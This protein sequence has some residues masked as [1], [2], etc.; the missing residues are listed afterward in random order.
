MDDFT[1]DDNPISPAAAVVHSQ[2]TLVDASSEGILPLESIHFSH[3]NDRVDS[4]LSGASAPGHLQATADMNIDSG[5]I[6][7]ST[8][9]QPSLKEVDHQPLGMLQHNSLDSLEPP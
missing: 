5:P 3:E 9:S 1:V 7:S 8:H 2:P 4:N 6:V